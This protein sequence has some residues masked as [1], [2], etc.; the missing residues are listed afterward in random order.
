MRENLSVAVE[1]EE[2]ESEDEEESW[3]IYETISFRQK[4][5]PPAV[6]FEVLKKFVKNFQSLEVLKLENFNFNNGNEFYEIL[7]NFKFLKSLRLKKCEL[8]NFNANFKNFLPNLIEILL[9]KSNFNFLTVAKSFKSLQSVEIVNHDQTFSGFCHDRFNKLLEALPNIKTLTFDG[10][11]TSSYFDNSNFPF[12]IQKLNVDTFTFDFSSQS[13]R[14]SF[15][16][17][18]QGFLKDLRMKNLPNDDDGGEIIKFIIDEMNLRNFYY[19]NVALIKDG[20][21]NA[22]VDEIWMSESQIKAGM[23]L[24]KQ[25]KSELR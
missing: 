13:P 10:D 23:E 12:K 20:R 14:I 19:R 24:M 15:L 5:R 9:E 8:Y 16:K 2:D 1:E 17:S 7:R 11:G 3:T 21:K 6:N 4:S 25:F 22:K 18:Q